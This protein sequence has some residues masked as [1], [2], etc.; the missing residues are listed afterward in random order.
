[1]ANLSREA[2]GRE[3][4]FR[5]EAEHQRRG[6]EELLAQAPAAMGLL[7]GSDHRWTYVNDHYV[8]LTGRSSTADFVG[9]TLVESF[10]EMETQVFTSLLDEV[11]RSGNPYFGREMKA[12]LNRSAMG[13]PD[14]CYWDFVYQPIRDANGA[15]E[16]ILVHA[17]DVTDKVTAREVIQE[18]T[19]RLLLAQA[20]AQIGTWEWDPVRDFRRLSPELHRLFGTE[21]SDPDHAQRWAERVHPDDYQRVLEQMADASRT[22][23]MDFEYRYLHPV[24]GLR[25]FYCKGRRFRQETRIFGVVQD[26]T[27]RKQAEEALAES[28]ERYRTVAETA[29]DAIVSINES[30]TVLFANSAIAR[31]FGYK[32]DELI[33]KNLAMLMPDYMRHLHHT[34]IQ[35]YVASGKRHLN[36]NATELPGLHKD[37]REIPLEVSFGEYTKGGRHYFTGFARDITQR[38]AAEQA[39]RESEQKLRVIT[40]AAPVMIWMAGTDKLCFYFNR[41]WLDF[42]GRTLEQEMGNGWAENVHP[43]DFDRCLQIYMSSFDARQ[44]FEMEYRLLHRSGE[45]RWILDHGVPRYTHDGKFEGYVGGCLDIHDQKHAAEQIR[46]AGEDVRR[47]HELLE[48][49][50]AASAT[51]TFRWN[52]RTDGIE[53]DENLRQ[54]LR[55]S[56]AEPIA[57]MQEFTARIHPHDATRFRFAI[58]ACRT[59]ADLDLEFRLPLANGQSR[60]LYGRAKMQWVNGQPNF[61]VGACTDI[62]SRKHAE[63]SLRESELWIAGQKQAFQAAV[64]GASLSA[65]LDI[66]VRTAVKQFRGEARCAFYVADPSG[67]GLTHVAGM[68]DDYA[69]CADRFKIGPDSLACGLAAHSGAPRITPDVHEDPL[70]KPWLW[71]AARYDYR[72]CWSF[73]VKTSAGK[74]IGTLALYFQQ[75]R[76]ATSRD[77]QFANLLTNAAAIIIARH[78]EAQDKEHAERILRDNEQRMRLAQQAAGIGTF[79]FNPSTNENRWTPELES[80][81]GLAPGTFGGTLEAWEQLVHPEDRPELLKQVQSGFQTEAPCQAEWRIVWPNGSTHWILGR[82]QVVKEQSGAPAC[83][84]GINIDITTRKAAQDARRHLAAIV[85]SS[86]DAILSKDLSGIVRSWNPQAERLFGYSAKEMIGEQIRTIVPAEM[87]EDEDRI[88]ATIAR[89]DR[90]EHFETIRVAKDG[91]RI[92]VSLT[93][94][95]IRDES[96]C[97]IGASTIVRDITQKKQT[98]L[99]LRMTERLASVGRL[100]A[101][102]A[103]EINNPLEAATN[104]LYLARSAKDTEQIHVL[105][106][107]TEE[108]LNR[109]A[110][111]SRQTLGFYREKNGARPLKIGPILEGLITV[112]ARKARN[113]SIEIESELREVPEIVAIESEIRQVLSN[114]LNNAIDAISGGGKIRIRVSAARRWGT[115]FVC[116]IRVTIAD[117]GR[118]I[119]PEHRPKLFE[120]FFTFGKDVGTGLGLWISKGIA[121]RHEGEIRFRTSERPGKSGTVFTFFLPSQT[122]LELPQARQA[123]SGA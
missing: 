13:L 102:I 100:A 123:P 104:L 78:R 5:A 27:D 37:G 80:I 31:V 96:A 52:V 1:M 88:L 25:W 99:A 30:S 101:T 87:Q 62:T 110:L 20:A 35:R 117:S 108:E 74:A 106:A 22:G 34:G 118:G 69:E 44:P 18:N 61:L 43:D 41:S 3:S 40:E 10:P 53:F 81:H 121:E 119:P 42:V 98:E 58:D 71:L 73:P 33:G 84:V 93:I 21:A 19:D 16:G 86:E 49:A 4:S 92:D 90:I 116:G 67:T 103:H 76:Q 122:S 111:L 24:E 68:P 112:F 72:A 6:L 36:W 39:L 55:F 89:G 9:K 2:T 66:L 120:P 11:Y 47:N 15:V 79:E 8:R 64:T 63:E 51:G 107:Q 114:L 60:W 46:A 45:Y 17:V 83:V 75:P 57:T 32:P 7:A 82:W 77:L 91:R 48:V 14:E 95:P 59:G 115:K 56:P 29:S 85:E 28:E 54:L 94:S 65:C 109:V 12:I 26:I 50:L 38:K 105:L 97:I 23:Q 70:W 113:K